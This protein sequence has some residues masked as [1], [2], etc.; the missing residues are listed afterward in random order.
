MD[1]KIFYYKFYLVLFE[2]SQKQYA[3]LA[4]LNLLKFD[5]TIDQYFIKVRSY[6]FFQLCNRKC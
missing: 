5:H 1:Y 4:E 3:P 6:H 2:D